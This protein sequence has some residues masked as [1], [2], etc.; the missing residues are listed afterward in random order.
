MEMCLD[1]DDGGKESQNIYT[2]SE[3]GDIEKLFS[4]AFGTPRHNE[5]VE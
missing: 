2:R 4:D 5:F 3:M 1:R